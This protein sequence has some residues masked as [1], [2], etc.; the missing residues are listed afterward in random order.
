MAY[1]AT[2]S[3]HIS[4][5]LCVKRTD[6]SNPLVQT[7]ACSTIGVDTAWIAANVSATQGFLIIP[8]DQ[9]TTLTDVEAD[10]TTGDWRYIVRAVV[11]S[12]FADY[13]AIATAN[14]PGKVTVSRGSLVGTGS[15]VTRTYSFKFALDSS[16]LEVAAE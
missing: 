12:F 11:E 3:S 14:L 8:I 9:L 1:T 2:P 7:D 5:L 15:E 13:D 16:S 10:E 4:G 6:G